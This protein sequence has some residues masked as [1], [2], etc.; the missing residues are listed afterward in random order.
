MTPPKVCAHC[1][2][3]V[4][5]DLANGKLAPVKVRLADGEIVEVPLCARCRDDRGRWLRF[6]PVTG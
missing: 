6:R 2:R 4:Q 5:R 3:Q 1:G